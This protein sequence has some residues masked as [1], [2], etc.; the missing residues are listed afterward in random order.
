MLLGTD[1]RY[2]S[3]YGELGC[4]RCLECLVHFFDAGGAGLR[5]GRF[6]CRERVKTSAQLQVSIRKP[7]SNRKLVEIARGIR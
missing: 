4:T 2:R 5:Q 7:K 1:A 3:R 6:L